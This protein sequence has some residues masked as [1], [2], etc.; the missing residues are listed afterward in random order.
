MSHHAEL[1]LED[2]VKLG[3]PRNIDFARA[4]KELS[5]GLENPW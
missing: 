2:L 4:Q 1:I 3:H 5:V